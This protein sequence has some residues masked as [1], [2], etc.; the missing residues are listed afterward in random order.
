MSALQPEKFPQL[1]PGFI[2]NLKGLLQFFN[3]EGFV[4]DVFQPVRQFLQLCGQV[5]NGAIIGFIG[6][7]KKRKRNSSFLIQVAEGIEVSITGKGCGNSVPGQRDG[8]AFDGSDKSFM[9]GT[10]SRGNSFGLG[11]VDKIIFQMVSA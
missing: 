11:I 7:I 2:F 3:P 8:A 10:K 5:I 4:K 6:N 9:I 1:F